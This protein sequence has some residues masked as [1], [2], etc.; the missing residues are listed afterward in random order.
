MQYKLHV[1]YIAFKIKKNKWV[2]KSQHPSQWYSPTA[3]QILQKVAKIQDPKI[4][5]FISISYILQLL[6]PQE[7][8]NKK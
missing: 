7:E 1:L 6:T 2:S 5:D 4:Q 8:G 3:A